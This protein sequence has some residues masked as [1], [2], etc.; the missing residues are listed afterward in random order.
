MSEDSLNRI[1]GFIIL[2]VG[3][4]GLVC[5]ATGLVLQHLGTNANMD[6]VGRLVPGGLFL[7]FAGMVGSATFHLFATRTVVVYR[8]ATGW[9]THYEFRPRRE[10]PCRFWLLAILYPFLSVSMLVLSVAAFLGHF[11]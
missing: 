8:P 10:H 3:G 7:L 4:P 11:R 9:R 5:A 2:S 1:G 6:A